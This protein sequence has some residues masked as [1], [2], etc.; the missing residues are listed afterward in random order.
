MFL[1]VKLPEGTFIIDPGF[2]FFGARV[3]VPLDGTVATNGRESHRL[4][5]DG[6]F[7]MMRAQVND[8]NGDTWVTTLEEENPVDFEIGN[9]FTSTHPAS[10]FVN[11]IMMSAVTPEGR[12]TIMNRE[13]TIWN[14]GSRRPILLEDR[15]ALRSMAAVY[16]GFD[17]PEIEKLRVPTIPQWS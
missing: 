1:S 14:D 2:G 8:K 17:L 7:Y 3:P 6:P 9:H 10:A 16:F 12:V 11:R 4:V 13:A 5:R 15:A